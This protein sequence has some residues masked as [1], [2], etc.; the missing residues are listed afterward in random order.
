VTYVRKDLISECEIEPKPFPDPELDA[1][2]DPTRPELVLD[3]WLN[4]YK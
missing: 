4:E 1:S 2:S 3:Y